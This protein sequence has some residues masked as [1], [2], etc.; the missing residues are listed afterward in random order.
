MKLLN[1]RELADFIKERQ[2]Q[3][4]RG[5]RQAWHVQPK[6]AIIVTVDHPAIKV[7]V[8]KKQRYGSDIGVKVEEHR[9][10]QADVPEVIE[11]LNNDP[12]VHGVIVQLPLEDPSQTEDIVNLVAPG[13]SMRSARMP[14]SI[15]RHQWQF[16]GCLLAT[17]SICGGRRLFSWVAVV[18]LVLHWSVS[19]WL[20]V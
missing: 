16:S 4:I 8:R 9:I 10:A 17:M 3:Q 18:S 12:S 11:N 6:L 20:Q 19:S 2:A 1:G 5:L 13:M 14:S 15:R 7:Y